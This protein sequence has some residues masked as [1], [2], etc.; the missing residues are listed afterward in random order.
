MSHSRNKD[1]KGGE[2]SALFQYL[3]DHGYS[4]DEVLIDEQN[5]RKFFCYD[6][7]EH[8]IE[9]VEWF[10][11]RGKLDGFLADLRDKLYLFF[12]KSSS[13]HMAKVYAKDFRE[14]YE[15]LSDEEILK[16]LEGTSVHERWLMSLQR[17]E[18]RSGAVTKLIQKMAEHGDS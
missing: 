17:A 11:E 16:K 8:L 18:K 15:G 3:L 4:R 6:S 5:C 14:I 13:H 1:D 12:L 10:R 2:Q 7:E 9:K